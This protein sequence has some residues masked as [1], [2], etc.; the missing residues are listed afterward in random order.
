MKE[1]GL[2]IATQYGFGSLR[3]W[4]SEK[5]MAT[6]KLRGTC[7]IHGNCYFCHTVNRKI[8]NPII[9]PDSKCCCYFLHLIRIPGYV[10]LLVIVKTSL[11]MKILSWCWFIWLK[12]RV[13]IPSQLLNLDFILHRL[14]YCSLSFSKVSQK[15]TTACCQTKSLTFYSQKL[16]STSLVSHFWSVVASLRIQGEFSRDTER[17]SD[18]CDSP[19]DF[20]MSS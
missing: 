14:A 8:L 2:Q 20:Q 17:P 7:G 11:W 16:I 10:R 3:S 1:W 6:E 9:L 15:G 12:V 4:L 5:K 18:S 19:L 13:F